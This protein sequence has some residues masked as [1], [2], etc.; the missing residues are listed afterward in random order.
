MLI[1]GATESLLHSPG[2]TG[3]VV[4]AAIQACPDDDRHIIVDFSRGRPVGQAQDLPS[5]PARYKDSI[6][7][8]RR[9]EAVVAQIIAE[10]FDDLDENRSDCQH[11]TLQKLLLL[12]VQENIP[13]LFA[14]DWGIT[15]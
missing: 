5:P 7:L 14:P 6:R 3:V 2:S 11:M 15:S 10:V 12:C 8:R 9:G 1:K 4:G 13:N